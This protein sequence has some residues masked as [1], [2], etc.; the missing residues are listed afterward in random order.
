MDQ[1]FNNREIAI[2]IWLLIFLSWVFTKEEV[3]ESAKHVLITFC[4]P[5]I[6]IIFALMFGYVYLVVDFMSNTGLWNLGQ[7]KNTIMWLILVA[8]IE[9]FKANTSYEE[10]GYFKKSIKSHF[11]LLVALEFVVAFHNFSLIA[12]LII[13]P[14]STLA[15]L[16]LEV[17]KLKKEHRQVEKVISWVLS[18]FGI[19]MIGFGLYYISLNFDQFAQS[20]TFAD[21]ITP[22]I[23]SIFL[24]PFIFV[25]SIYILY[26]RILTRVNIYT[27]HKF[28]RLY[29]KIKGLMH[30]KKDHKNLDNWLAYSCISD[31]V[32]KK[33]IDDSITL[34]ESRKSEME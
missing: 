6:L 9:L 11:K 26:E 14:I 2:S 32:S 16:T 8:S 30:F 19:L 31:F 25:L 27:N 1:I 4:Q 21:F 24:L 7:L 15:V 34:Y 22:I 29:G 23:L 12:E 5:A 20:K 17:S 3:R 33:A 28:Y 18:V 13:V 10:K